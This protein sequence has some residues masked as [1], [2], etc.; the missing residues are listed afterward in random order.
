MSKF[1]YVTS[2]SDFKKKERNLLVSLIKQGART[3]GFFPSESEIASWGANV[4]ALKEIV[5][6]LHE[7][8][9]IG[10]EY[11]LPAGGRIDCVLMGLDKGGHMNIYHV[12]LKQWSN[13][14][15]NVVYDQYLYQVDVEGCRGGVS[16]FCA[17]PSQ[18]V[19]EYH[20]Y[21]LNNL[22][23]FEQEN[24]S[25][26]GLAYC[27][28]YKKEDT[29]SNLFNEYYND[30]LN[31]YPVYTRD[32]LSELKEELKK[33]LSNG[34]GEKVYE[35]LS[36]SEVRPTK[37]L[38]TSIANMFNGSS[39]FQLIGK[40][41]DAYNAILGSINQSNNGKTVIIVKGGPGTGK[42]V[43]ALRLAAEL[44]RNNLNVK[45]ATRSSSLRSGLKRIL[46]VK[47]PQGLIDS[48]FNIKP[49]WYEESALDAILIDEAHRI[50]ENS[51]HFTQ[52]KEDGIEGS[53]FLPQALSIIYSSRVSVFF[54]DDNQSIIPTEIGVS[55]E[56]KRYAEG[57][58]DLIKKAIE[59]KKQEITRK[60]NQEDKEKEFITFES[61]KSFI[62]PS[63]DEKIRVIEI[64]LTDQF[65]CNGND[66]YLE[67]LND[68]LYNG[69]KG[70]K[71]FSNYEFE[72]FDNPND[73]Y[74]KIR[75]KDAFASFC[76]TECSGL[77]YEEINKK[78]GRKSFSP[79]ARLSAGWCWPWT[80]NRTSDGDLVNEVSFS[81]ETWNGI[82]FKFEMPWET[83]G[84]MPKGKCRYK[85]AKNAQLWSTEP[86][87]VNQIGAVH[88]LQGWDLD[89]AGVIIGPDLIYDKEND[90]LKGNTQT[91]VNKQKGL[92][93][94]SE[95]MANK[96]FK[97][98][99]RV[100]MSRG[101]KGCYVFCCDPE[102]GKFIK[103]HLEKA[104]S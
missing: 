78:I 67:W 95:E 77:S 10:F 9:Y 86:Q 55:S 92:E 28:N 80:D 49:N 66:G 51:N 15:I 22:S 23:V 1:F 61:Q 26:H 20:N 40:Q 65:R 6:D 12:E 102:V 104:L 17:H 98:I 7:D 24:I 14:R 4:D 99:Y 44:S 90:C 81:G 96:Y 59:D 16:R 85:Y 68:V 35:Q 100:L 47:Y 33:S 52:R 25:L 39:E 57:Y 101:M 41:L 76:D 48:T 29:N 19:G 3:Q 60:R 11:K 58:S 82:P 83:L 91:G 46:G 69:G 79:V 93:R 45:Y 34:A 75:S 84:S 50:G 97:N 13:D 103:R 62:N 73:L 38:R 27:Y 53:T 74:K 88:A 36:N 94:P 70:E 71:T 64:E 31:E 5:E 2:V 56:L 87:G 63:C 43:I 30:I 21:L 18:Q 37:H 72:V 89:Y 8:V 54:I 32:T 42:S